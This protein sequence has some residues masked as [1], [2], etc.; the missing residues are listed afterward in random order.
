MAEE[1]PSSN[2]GRP[3]GFCLLGLESRALGRYGSV[4]SVEL[5]GL[6]SAEEVGGARTSTGGGSMDLREL[7][8]GGGRTRGGGEGEVEEDGATDEE[9]GSSEGGALAAG[10][11]AGSERPSMPRTS[12]SGTGMVVGEGEEA[13]ERGTGA[14]ATPPTT[15]RLGP[16]ML[17]SFLSTGEVGAGAGTG[18]GEGAG[19]GAPVPSE[20]GG[21]VAEDADGT[22]PATSSS[23]RP[24]NPTLPLL[25]LGPIESRARLRLT[26]GRGCIVSLRSSRVEGRKLRSILACS[27]AFSTRSSGLLVVCS[28]PDRST[29]IH[30]GTPCA[31]RSLMNSAL[32]WDWPGPAPEAEPEAVAVA[33]VVGGDTSLGL[34]D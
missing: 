21:R 32:D 6:V 18:A 19:V 22:V 5:S 23:P 28:C 16:D 17:G 7:R 2:T 14:P 25:H 26:I 29:A 33:V 1:S 8:E 31:T 11:G 13:A 9:S 12:L 4:F 34:P 3:K 15:L 20:E 24:P 27:S 30:S 10:A